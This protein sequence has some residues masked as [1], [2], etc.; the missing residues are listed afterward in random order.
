LSQDGKSE[1]PPVIEDQFKSGLTN[2]GSR[3]MSRAQTAN[4]GNRTNSHRDY[5]LERKEM[6]EI[7]ES[8]KQMDAFDEKY[9]SVKS[10]VGYPRIALKSDL[11]KF[12]KYN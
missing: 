8:M 3:N 5:D 11:K 4:V 10:K 7:Q 2:Y 1:A 12:S 6:E 9:G